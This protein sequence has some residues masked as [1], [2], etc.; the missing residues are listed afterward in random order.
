MRLSSKPCIALCHIYNRPADRKQQKSSPRKIG[1]LTY[2]KTIKEI[3][4][5]EG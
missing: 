3:D 2:K 5:S 1:V 4:M